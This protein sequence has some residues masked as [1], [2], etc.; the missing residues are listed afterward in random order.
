M[1][2]K[3]GEKGAAVHLTGGSFGRDVRRRVLPCVIGGQSGRRIVTIRYPPRSMPL[4]D[5]EIVTHRAG[6]PHIACE[7]DSVL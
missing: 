3:A 6:E 2:G 5:E 1:H 7:F 4:F